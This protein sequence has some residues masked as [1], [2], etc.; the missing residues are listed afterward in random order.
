[1]GGTMPATQPRRIEADSID[2]LALRNHLLD[3]AT[4][5]DT[6]ILLRALESVKTED[7]NV[8]SWVRYFLQS[9]GAYL[10]K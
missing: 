7:N 10:D 8:V 3:H 6:V 5:F 9:A 4:H 2:P 1:M